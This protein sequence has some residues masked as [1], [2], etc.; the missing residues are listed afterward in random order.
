MNEN[1]I[2]FDEEFE[3]YSNIIKSVGKQA[4]SKLNTLVEQLSIVAEE[5][6]VEGN[7]HDNLVTFISALSKMQNQFSFYTETLGKDT[8][9]YLDDVEM[10]DFSFYE[11]GRVD[12]WN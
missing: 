1:L 8:I 7:V 12:G 10:K 6:I 11:G 4:E 3:E 9:D 5:G 2:I